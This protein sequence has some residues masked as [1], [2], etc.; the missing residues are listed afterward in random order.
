MCR[1]M[2]WGVVGARI[3]RNLS[4]VMLHSI[5]LKLVM[6]LDIKEIVIQYLL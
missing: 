4:D 1:C 6:T 2:V 3:S 5:K